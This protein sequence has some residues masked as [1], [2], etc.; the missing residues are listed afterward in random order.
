MVFGRVSTVSATRLLTGV[1]LAAMRK[2]RT[3]EFCARASALLFAAAAFALLAASI[4]QTL[5]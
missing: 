5:A 2:L 1:L 4:L 3:I